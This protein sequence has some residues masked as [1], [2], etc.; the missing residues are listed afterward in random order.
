MLGPLLVLRALGW[1]RRV[2]V[3][4]KAARNKKLSVASCL[5]ERRRRKRE[6]REM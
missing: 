5:R 3:N 6:H 4:R 1:G 2:V